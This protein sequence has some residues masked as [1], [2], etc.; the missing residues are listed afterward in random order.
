M[1]KGTPCPLPRQC[2]FQTGP[3][4]SPLSASTHSTTPT[5]SGLVRA[6]VPR[7]HACADPGLSQCSRAARMRLTT[8]RGL[9]TCHG[10]SGIA[11]RTGRSHLA[12]PLLTTTAG[13]LASR[14]TLCPSRASPVRPRRPPHAAITAR[15]S[16]TQTDGT[17]TP[18]RCQARS[19]P[20][21]SHYGHHSYRGRGRSRRRRIPHFIPADSFANS[22]RESSLFHSPRDTVPAHRPNLNNRLT[23]PAR[24][25][26][27]LL[28]R[29]RHPLVPIQR[30]LLLL[31]L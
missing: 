9:K 10:G 5:R 31:S 20:I 28:C 21:Q 22:R 6:G 27:L 26:R 2:R 24:F 30:A 23:P 18:T 8:A 29:P 25:L 12:W 14:P 15:P 13:S 3:S 7:P 19:R 16:R 11:S 4:T 1:C 17:T